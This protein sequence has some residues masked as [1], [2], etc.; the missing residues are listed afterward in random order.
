VAVSITPFELRYIIGAD[1]QVD[2]FF[3]GN[4]ELADD[5][6]GKLYE[7]VALRASVTGKRFL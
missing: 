2:S 1:D 3:S 5:V 4:L 7:I 6:L